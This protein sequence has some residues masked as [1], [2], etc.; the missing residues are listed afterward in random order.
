M[1]WRDFLIDFSD[2]VAPKLDTYEH[3]IY[4]YLIRHTRLINVAE[5]V[6]GFKSA[7]ARMATG[8]GENGKPMSE[9]TAYVKL[10]SLA[11]KGLVE[12]LASEHKGRRIGVLLPREVPGLIRIPEPRAEVDPD[13]LDF[14]EPPENRILILEREN[15]ACFYCLKGLTQET[16][17]IEHVISRPTG[18]NSYRN[19]VASCRQCNTRKGSMSA[20]DFVRQIFSE[21]LLNDVEVAM[22]L[23]AI[24]NLRSGNLKPDFSRATQP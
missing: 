3:A 13:S 6:I 4:I 24:E 12:L 10:Q 2:H 9:N 22:R 14:F 19:V 20:E 23:T 1:E 8:I 11:R 21:G 7:R 16:F 17:L 5:A 18:G 15:E